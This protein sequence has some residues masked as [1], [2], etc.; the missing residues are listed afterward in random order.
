MTWRRNGTEPPRREAAKIAPFASFSGADATRQ[1]VA[2]GVDA[3]CVATPDDR[4]F[5]AAKLA[6]AAGKHV[7]IENVP[8][9]VCS[10]CGARYFAANVLK[11]IEESVRGRRKA[12]REITVPVYSF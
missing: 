7:L 8:A 10:H 3:V 6:L 11:T 9:G 5:E 2:H 12:E 1:L 4:H